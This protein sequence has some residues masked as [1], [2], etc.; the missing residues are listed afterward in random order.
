MTF[1]KFANLAE[2][3]RINSLNLSFTLPA[4]ALFHK[5]RIPNIINP[6]TI[7]TNIFITIILELFRIIQHL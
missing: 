7:I 6:T 1:K 3:Y 2:F 4:G 5:A